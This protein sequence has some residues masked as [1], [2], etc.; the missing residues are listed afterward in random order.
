MQQLYCSSLGLW[1]ITK[2]IKKLQVKPP[3]FTSVFVKL[4]LL[5]W[6]L[7]SLEYEMQ[8]KKKK[9]TTLELLSF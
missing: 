4:S 9:S 3:L 1:I 8:L 2:K 6:H 7:L 5:I